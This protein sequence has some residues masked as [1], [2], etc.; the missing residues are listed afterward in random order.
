MLLSGYRVLDLTDE[1]GILSGKLLA[2]LGAEVIAVEPPTGNGARRLEPHIGSDQA[3]SLCWLAYAAGKKGITLAL[4]KADGQALLRCL[5][6]VSDVLLESFPPG[7]MAGLGLAY[8]LL[9]Q[10]NPALVACAVTPFG[11]NGPYSWYSATDLTIMAAGGLAYLTGDEDR[12]PVRISFPQASLIAASAAAAGVAIALFHRSRTGEGQFIDVSAQHAVARTLDRA[13]A[14]WDIQGTMLSRTGS[15]GRP[16]GGT[17]RRMTWQCQDGYLAFFLLGGMTGARNME[18]LA[19]WMRDTGF[20]PGPLQEIR[21]DELDFFAIPQEVLDRVSHVIEGFFAAFTKEEAW[22]QAR[23]RRLLLYPVSEPGEVYQHTRE[24]YPD[25]FQPIPHPELGK[26]LE[27][28]GP[29]LPVAGD[30]PSAARGPALGEHNQEVYGELLGLSQ[31][32]L[33]ILRQGGLI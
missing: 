19:Q 26:S 22:R 21:W 11:Q 31:P 23:K 18:A 32:E 13:S 29:F 17:L 16:G 1:W 24:I 30:S 27:Y 7:H 33:R 4:E 10:E 5:V 9:Q 15:Q 8:E 25:F 14:F 6:A 28:L 3:Q 20:D 12:P 2:D